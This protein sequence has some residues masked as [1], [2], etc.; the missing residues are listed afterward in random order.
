LKY[1]QKISR[2]IEHDQTFTY[3][4]TARLGPSKW[5]KSRSEVNHYRVPE[6][7]LSVLTAETRKDPVRFKVLRSGITKEV[8]VQRAP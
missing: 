2:Q 4:L 8:I 5:I 3:N 6:T 1:G 7:P